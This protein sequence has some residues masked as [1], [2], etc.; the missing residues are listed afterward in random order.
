MKR[1]SDFSPEPLLLVF[2]QARRN[3]FLQ[4]SFNAWIK[5]NA[6]AEL[7]EAVEE[8]LIEREAFSAAE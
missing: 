1:L 6:L 8:L 7:L 3:K 2:Y 4:Y 5:R